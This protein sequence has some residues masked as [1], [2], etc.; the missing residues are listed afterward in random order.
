[1]IFNA[2]I[3]NIFILK[4]GPSQIKELGRKFDG[5]QPGTNVYVNNRH[6]HTFYGRHNERK[7]HVP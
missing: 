7:K 5:V 6:T 3:G 4:S 2:T 1:L